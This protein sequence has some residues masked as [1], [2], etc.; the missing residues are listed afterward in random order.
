MANLLLISGKQ[1]RP[2]SRGRVREKLIK[3]DMQGERK[4]QGE[5]ERPG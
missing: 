5:G 3:R 1:A 2:K 4:K